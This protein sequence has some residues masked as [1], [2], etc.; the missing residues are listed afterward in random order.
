MK[1]KP[2]TAQQLER[3]YRRLLKAYGPQH[4]W[5]ADSRFE[6]M[7]GAILTQNTAWRNVERAVANLKR[8]GLMTPRTLDRVPLSR[9]AE[10]I[11]PSGYFRVKAGRV[12]AFVR[13]L[14][15]QYEGDLKR[16]KSEPVGILRSKLL[17]VKGIGPETADSILLYA[18]DVPVFVIDAYTR[19]VLNRHRL[20][21]S[22]VSYDQIQLFF[23]GHLHLRADLYNEY[24]ALLVKVGKEH[25]K[26]TPACQGCPLRVYLNGKQP[27]IW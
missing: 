8:E 21:P 6:I 7:I 26:P 18:L 19:R 22:K 23:M 20:I 25:C 2:R 17:S 15:Q 3:Y 27:K 14:T 10:M 9:L 12:K 24:H 13:F 5:P 11:R 1:E 4:W 16:M